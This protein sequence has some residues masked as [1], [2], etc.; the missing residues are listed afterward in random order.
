MDVRIFD[1]RYTAS[2]ENLEKKLTKAALTE[3]GYRKTTT[4]SQEAE[5][6]RGTQFRK[7]VRYWKSVP[8]QDMARVEDEIRKSMPGVWGNEVSIQVR[9]EA[10]KERE[11]GQRCTAGIEIH[12]PS[13]RC[14]K[15]T[16]VKREI[17]TCSGSDYCVFC[18]AA[19]VQ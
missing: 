18:F 9:N 3:R 15:K 5:D 2:K 14:Q 19:T 11:K 13:K 12:F 10:L 4:F 17:P 16:N 1:R 7:T 8:C 6:A